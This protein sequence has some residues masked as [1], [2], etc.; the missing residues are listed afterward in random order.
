MSD[1]KRGAKAV[2]TGDLRTGKGLIDAD[3]GVLRQVS[4]SF[5]TRF[6]NE[7]G[8]NPEELIASAHAACYSMAFADTLSGK[9]YRPEKIETRA[10][11][12]MSKRGNGFRITRMRLEVR[13]QVPDMDEATFKEIAEKADE[14]CPVSNLLRSG[15]EIELSASLA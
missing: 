2:W 6:M 11:C 4:Y 9:G 10:I 15:L 3:S 8:T 1:I 14:V 5:A 7:T 13:G 12:T